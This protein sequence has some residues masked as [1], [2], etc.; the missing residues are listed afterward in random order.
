MTQWHGG[1]GSTRR[2]GADNDKFRD[3]YDRIFGK[4]NDSKSKGDS[5][6]TGTHGETPKGNTDSDLSK[7]GR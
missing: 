7:T 2:K 4:Q 3:G 6:T 5:N 1:K